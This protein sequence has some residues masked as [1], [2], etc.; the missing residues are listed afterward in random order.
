M[1][2]IARVAHPVGVGL[3]RSGNN[4]GIGFG[5]N[6]RQFLL[7]QRL[8][9]FHELAVGKTQNPPRLIAVQQLVPVASLQAEAGPLGDDERERGSNDQ[10]HPEG[11]RDRVDTEV[12][13][14]RDQIVA[15]GKPEDSVED[16]G[17]DADPCPH[18][19]VAGTIEQI[20]FALVAGGP[21]FQEGVE[22]QS[23]EQ[24]PGD[25]HGWDEH[26]PRDG[27]PGDDRLPVWHETK[28]AVEPADVPVGLGSGRH[29]VGRIGTK[30][31]DRVDVHQA[32]QQGDDAED[33]EEEAARL[34]HVNGK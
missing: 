21:R 30:D 28:C 24:D 13:S 8:V 23:G 18:R 34:R 2:E 26:V 11:P 14:R 33:D 1:N 25:H 16:D 10:Q 5:T 12:E 15:A 31:P 27:E 20:V 29:L 22:G 7:V 19:C 6:D 4:R 9:H 3:L 32:A 17:H